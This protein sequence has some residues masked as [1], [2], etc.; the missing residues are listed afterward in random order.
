M[1][2]LKQKKNMRKIN[3]PSKTKK[4]LFFLFFRTIVS[5]TPS[6]HVPYTPFLKFNLSLF[7][8]QRVPN[9][10]LQLFGRLVNFPRL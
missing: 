3:F 1:K 4:P 10:W 6:G 8:I 2:Y 5:R 9:P 7:S